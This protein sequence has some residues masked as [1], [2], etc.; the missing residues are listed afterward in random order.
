M[1]I[2][3][4]GMDG[5]HKRQD[6]LKSHFVQVGGQRVSMVEI[7]GA[8]ITFDLQR[9]TESIQR[10]AAGEKCGWL[11]MTECFII[12]WKTLCK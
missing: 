8:P 7:K 12:R 9:L 2:Q 1:P 5:F 10:V 4:I 6:Y 3:A 11:T